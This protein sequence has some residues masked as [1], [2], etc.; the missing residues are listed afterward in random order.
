ML[1]SKQS[2]V[3]QRVAPLGIYESNQPPLKINLNQ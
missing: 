2:I 1:D 3:A